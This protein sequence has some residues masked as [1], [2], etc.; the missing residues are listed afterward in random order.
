M[1]A[2][3]TGLLLTLGGDQP[4]V[5]F[6][7]PLDPEVFDWDPDTL[8]LKFAGEPNCPDA[9]RHCF[10]CNAFEGCQPEEVQ[11]QSIVFIR[12][13]L[14]L[15]STTPKT[16]DEEGVGYEQCTFEGSTSMDGPYYPLRLDEGG[17]QTYSPVGIGHGALIPPQVRKLSSIAFGYGSLCSE[18]SIQF[19]EFDRLIESANRTDELLNRVDALESAIESC[20]CASDLDGDGA[21]GFNDLVQLISDWGPCSA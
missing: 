20:N 14:L 2:S 1:L 19:L 11:E 15:S 7:P 12:S 3:L 21:V 18:G 9:F 6:I 8:T 4:A 17:E 13:V 5:V 10:T 16:V